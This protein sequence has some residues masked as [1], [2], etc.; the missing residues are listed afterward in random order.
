MNDH[1]TVPTTNADIVSANLVLN[2]IVGDINDPGKSLAELLETMATMSRNIGG[3][4]RAASS[5]WNDAIPTIVNKTD[6]EIQELV[7]RQELAIGETWAQRWMLM[8]LAKHLQDELERQCIES[9]AATAIESI[10]YTDDGRVETW[11]LR[12]TDK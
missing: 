12:K 1:D 10:V 8:H 2:A 9:P 11:S 5:D 6:K 3:D 7:S 4:H